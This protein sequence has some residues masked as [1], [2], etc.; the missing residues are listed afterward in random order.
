V[1]VNLSIGVVSAPFFNVFGVKATLGRTFAPDEDQPGKEKVVVLTHRFW[2][3]R[4]AA[5]PAVIGR[6]ILL[7]NE[8]YTVVGVLPATSA[9]DRRENDVWIP[10]AFPPNSPRNF[11]TLQAF[12]RLKPGVTIEQADAELKLIAA[13]IAERYPNEKKGWTATVDSFLDN[14]VGR[15][16]RLTLHVLMWAVVAVLLIGCANMANLLMAR[17]S[18]RSREIAVR[19]AIGASRGR[20]VR[21]LLTESLLFSACGALL[22]VPLGYGLLELMQG[23]MPVGFLPADASVTMDGRVLMFLTAATIFTSVA[24]GLAPALQSSGKESGE[25]LK[26]GSRASTSRTSKLF[27]RNVFVCE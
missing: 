18:L 13:G 27:A 11:H 6:P 20:L 3:N 7:D 24:I 17:S 15:Q 16:L 25:A 26:D 1:P 23:L 14:V 2:S 19:M 10:L 12:A 21:M 5:D 22:A 9:F 8:P 4:M